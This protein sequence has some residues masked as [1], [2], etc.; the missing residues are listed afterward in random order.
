LSRD[1]PTFT[2]TT[3]VFDATTIGSVL[4]N[5]TKDPYFA[6]LVANINGLRSRL[7]ADETLRE[8][9][10]HVLLS[11]YKSKNTKKRLRPELP[12]HADIISFVDEFWPDILLAEPSLV[13][14]SLD[15]SDSGGGHWDRV[16]GSTQC[17]V[18]AVPRAEVQILM[19][20]VKQW[21]E[22]VSTFTCCIN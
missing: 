3:A 13:G 17:G 8:P 14:D 12:T 22:S 1:S 7:I 21:V 10:L 16:W 9:L 15:K 4:P 11:L 5:I 6:K 18:D 19:P 20:L 2:K